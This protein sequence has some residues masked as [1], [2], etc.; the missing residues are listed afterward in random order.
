M[1][2]QKRK[3]LEKEFAQ[4]SEKLNSPEAQCLAEAESRQAT[5]PAIREH[6][7]FLARSREHASQRVVR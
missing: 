4:L 7:D 2:E 1:D 3:S 5:A 6:A